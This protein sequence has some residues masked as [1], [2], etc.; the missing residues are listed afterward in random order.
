MAHEILALNQLDFKI[1]I[2]PHS[3]KEDLPFKLFLP[4][5]HLKTVTP[6]YKRL[7]QNRKKL[8][9]STMIFSGVSRFIPKKHPSRE[10]SLANEVHSFQ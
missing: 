10:K 8:Y 1:S 9:F 7:T 3:T 6:R 2:P 4:T 5:T